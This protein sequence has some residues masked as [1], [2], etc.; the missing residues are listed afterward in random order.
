MKQGYISSAA[1]GLILRKSGKKMNRLVKRIIMPILGVLLGGVIVGV[2]LFLLADGDWVG[3][4]TI[5]GVGTIVTAFFMG[6]LIE[7]FNRIIARPLLGDK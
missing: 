6:P 4:L 1:S 3:I 5:A 7:L 2:C